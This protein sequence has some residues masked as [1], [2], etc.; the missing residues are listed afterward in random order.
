MPVNN[1]DHLR[2]LKS[3]QTF[4][5]SLGIEKLELGVGNRTGPCYVVHQSDIVARYLSSHRVPQIGCR[6]VPDDDH[7]V[8]EACIEPRFPENCHSAAVRDVGDWPLQV[9]VHEVPLWAAP[10][11]PE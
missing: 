4:G 2:G 11:A 5:C 1:G 6:G 7:K 9:S 3:G 8:W 10:H